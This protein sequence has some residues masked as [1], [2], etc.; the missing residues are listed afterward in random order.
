MSPV[1]FCV[2]IDNLLLLLSKA[3]VGCYIGPIFAGALAYADDIV[4]IA[5]TATALRKLLI[6]CDEYANDYSISFNAAKTKCLV[7]VPS[8]CRALFDGLHD[9]VFRIGNKPIEFVNSFCHLGHLINSELSDDEDIIKR[10]NNF[11]GQV[12]NTLC[13]FRSLDSFVQNKLFQS[14][15][16]SFYGCELWLLNNLKLEDLCVAWR[17]SM[18]KIWKLPQQSHRY[19]L[20]LISGC[21]PVFDELCRRSMNFVRSCLSHDSRIIQ[22]VANYAVMHARSQS[23]LG[24]NVLF[25][26]RRYKFPVSSTIL[27][28]L[29]SF[30]TLI[31]S[32]VHSSTDENMRCFANFLFELVMLRERRLY[33]SDSV[34]LTEDVNDIIYFICTS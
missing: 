17:K 8:S 13:Y 1:L 31:N 10:T 34:F 26:A 9:C 14:Y 28:E 18:R 24:R 19:L 23:F 15:C 4:L 32:F 27:D 21:L 16:T 5:P 20:H 22:F 11:I 30:D 3:G 7:A 25:C 33:L 29:V 6:I 12:N 2:Y